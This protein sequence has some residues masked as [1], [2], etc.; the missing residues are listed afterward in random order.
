MTTHPA[1]QAFVCA[2]I[3]LFAKTTATSLLQVATRVRTR[4]FVLPEDAA[5]LRLRPVPEEAAIVRRC[6]AV[7]RNDVENLP[8]FLALALAWTLS[9]AQAVEAWLL[10]GAYVALRYLHTGAYLAGLQPWRALLYLA[11]L[12]VCWTIAARLA[13]RVLGT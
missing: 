10:F 3:A 6:A 9:G 1:W 8:L 12:G 7:W 13:L 2:L 11:G 4:A 5:M